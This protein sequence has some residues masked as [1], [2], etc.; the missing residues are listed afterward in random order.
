MNLQS[1]NAPPLFQVVFVGL[2][3]LSPMLKSFVVYIISRKSLLGFRSG[4][5][6]FE[7]LGHCA[8][9][10]FIDSGVGVCVPDYRMNYVRSRLFDEICVFL[11]V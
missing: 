7:E 5:R 2:S 6:L 1:S 3:S 11:I 8:F 4:E 9:H 10:V